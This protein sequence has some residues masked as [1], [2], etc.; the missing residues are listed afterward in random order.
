M[1]VFR[2]P[3]RLASVLAGAIFLTACSGGDE[4]PVDPKPGVDAGVT[5]DAGDGPSGNDGGSNGGTDGGSNGGTDGGSNGGTDGGSNG[6]T[7]G[8]STGSPD[9]GGNTGGQDGGSNGGTDA[10][11]EPDTVAPVSPDQLLLTPTGPANNNAPVL[12]GRA[13]ALSTVRVYANGDCTGTPLAQAAASAAGAFSVAVNVV[14]NSSTTFRVTATDAAGNTSPCAQGPSYVEDSTPPAVP[15][16]TDRQP[17]SP[18]TSTSVTLSGTAEPGSRVRIHHNFQ[19][20]GVSGTE[21]TA[22]A[23]GVFS[24]VVTV[25]SNHTT[26]FGAFAIDAAGNTSACVQGPRYI[27]DTIAPGQPVFSS[28]QPASPSNSTTPTLSGT[29]LAGGT[30]RLYGNGT[31]AGSPLATVTADTSGAYSATVTVPSNGTTQ[32]SGTVTDL[33]GNTS[34]CGVGPTYV[35]DGEAP[36]A[37]VL[38]RTEPGSPANNNTPS[39]LGTAEA[40]STVRIYSSPACDG[41]SL[42]QASADASG[43]FSVAVNVA[44]SSTTTWY[45]A[46]TDA[47]GN[48]SPCGQGLSYVEDSAAPAAPVFFSTQPASPSD[49]L[50]PTLTG[51]AEAGSSVRLYANGACTGSPLATVTA[52]IAGAFSATVTVADNRA[53]DFSASATDGVGNTSACSVG[54]TYVHD[55]IAPTPPIFSGLQPASP[56]NSTMP[57]LTGIAEAGGTVRLYANGACTGSP[58]ATV[59]ADTA[60]AFSATVTVADNRATAFS[61]TVVDAVGNTS[62]CGVGPTYVHDGEAPAAPVLSRTEPGSPANNNTPSLLGTAEAGSTVRIYSSPTCDGASLAQASADASGAFSVAVSVADSSTTTWYATATDAAGNTSPCGQGLS[63]VEDSAAPAAPVFFSAQPASPSDNLTPTLTGTAESGSTVRLYANGACTGSPLATVTADIAGAFSATVTVADN[64]ATDFSAS[65]TD[66]V[67]NTSACAV[68]PTYVHDSIAPTPPIFSGLQP[69]SPSNSTMPTLTGIAEAGGTVRLYANGACTGSPV[70][71]VKAETGT[72]SASAVVASNRATD[73]SA[74]VVDAA[75]NTSA[76]GVGPTYVHDGEAPAA[77][78]LSRT[79]PGSPANHNAPRLVGT[80][81]AGSTVRIYTSATCTETPVA[82]ANADAFGA[83]SVV[84]NVDDNSRTTW[85]A[86]ATDAASNTSP[87]GQGLSY[88]ENSVIPPAPTFSGTQPVSPANNNNPVLSGTSEPSHTVRIFSTED[89]S[90]TPL[91]TVTADATTGAFSATVSVVNNTETTFRA[92]AANEV[93]NTSPCGPGVLYVEDSRAPIAPV[94]SAQPASP[95]N[96]N[97]PVVSGTTEAGATVRLYAAATCGGSPTATVKADDAG[98]FSVTVNVAD[99]STTTFRATATDAAGN[100]SS[101]GTAITYVEDSTPPVPPT[102]ASVQ[103]DSPSFENAIVLSGTAVAGGTVRVYT[104]ANCSGSPVAQGQ[105]SDQGTFLIDA[106]VADNTTTTFRATASDVAGNASACSA[107][108]TYVEDSA[109]PA[110]P[111]LAVQPASPANNN[112]P[113]VSGTTEPS[114]T[115]RIYGAAACA[116]AALATVK[117]D[118]AGAFSSTLSVQ[119]NSNNTFYATSTDVAGNTSACSSRLLYVE[120]S[121]APN[122]PVFISTVEPGATGNNNKPRVLGTAEPASTVRLYTTASCSGSPVAQM[123]ASQAGAWSFFVD[124]AD[125]TTTTFRA[126]ATDAAGNT[127][128]CAEGP[129]YR[130]DSTAPAAPTLAQTSPTSP[131]NSN[132]VVVSG[133]A[134]P[135]STVRIH[136][137]GACPATILTS[138]TANSTTGAFSGTVTVASDTTTRFTASAVDAAGNVSACASTLLTYIEDSTAPASASATVLDGTAGDPE[139]LTTTTRMDAR[140]QGFSDLNGVVRYERNLST[141]TQCAGDAIAS[142]DVGNVTAHAFTNQNLAERTY[143]NCVRALDAAGN[144]SAW[145]ASNGITVDVTPPLVVARNPAPGSNTGDIW[146]PVS[147]T[148]AEPVDASSFTSSNFRVR[149]NGVEIAGVHSCSGAT[150]SF[151][152]NSPVLH[153]APL[154]ATLSSGVKDLAGNVLSIDDTWAFMARDVQWSTAQRLPNTDTSLTSTGIDDTGVAHMVWREDQ[155]ITSRI[156]TRRYVPGAGW[157]SAQMLDETDGLPLSTSLVVTPSGIAH[158]VWVMNSG[159]SSQFYDLYS[160]TYQPGSGWGEA[161]L[162]SFSS[163]KTSAPALAVNTKGDVYVLWHVEGTSTLSPTLYGA[164]GSPAGVWST[165]SIV[166]TTSTTPVMYDIAVD[167]D[168]IGVAVWT[169]SGSSLQYAPYDMTWNFW[170]NPKSVPAPAVGGVPSAPRIAIGANGRGMVVWVNQIVAQNRFDIYASTYSKASGFGTPQLLDTTSFTTADP[171]VGIDANGTAFAAWRQG[172]S[173]STFDVAASRNTSGAWEAP[174]LLQQQNVTV[175]DLA[176]GS[177]GDAHVVYGQ[178]VQGVVNVSGRRYQPGTGWR[179]SQTFSTGN[180]TNISSLDVGANGFG[181]G[182]AC[183]THPSPT[184]TKGWA[185]VYN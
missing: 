117:A 180:G 162:I 185:S 132:S 57:T 100:G 77:P 172:N 17:D 35:H 99:D 56:S 34:T 148:F 181:E 1:S 178:S 123:T 40:G 107:G 141:T 130:E 79:E 26:D 151:K 8:G 62:A 22:D 128:G 7:D 97:A 127:S 154:A 47:A 142:V 177:A 120:D 90:G 182:A 12:S 161:H 137:Q 70:S 63:Y 4:G 32:F 118:A 109:A 112:S 164:R 2:P 41:A 95:A 173:S 10:G 48:T 108:I 43:A 114:A 6:G 50:T 170:A 157:Q 135:G 129:S 82:Q 145:K 136:T 83:F 37:P 92:T 61:A 101:C 65:A 110:P 93:G 71:T 88:V 134:E 68:G 21:V 104:T 78:V 167:P 25:T 51:T 67:G 140:W 27:H 152:F 80:A 14:D 81:E 84:V 168:G 89:C 36:A 59:T 111:S 139:W 75:G 158:A 156:M 33:A 184:P 176:V 60:G 58:L 28:L 125:D 166:A 11:E 55:S 74:S 149:D 98:A 171:R 175:M 5:P 159:S 133:S 102:L 116:G 96:N 160:A 31:C 91:A 46:A 53:T 3:W 113:V 146:G 163:S 85:H 20:A 144:A 126:T 39:L 76:C 147:V 54:P 155:T 103:P 29:A 86:T 115:V 150:C 119:N 19:C 69:A 138:V 13:E 73:F 131:S 122:L 121:T 94:L 23:S 52:D 143:Y 153:N 42:A 18:G 87:C 16:F 72:F 24:T 66:G 64:R 174:V 9:G 38:S 44:D 183:W 105:A 179:A 49:N 165:R 30:V 15:V 106:Q 45:A 169:G 124:V